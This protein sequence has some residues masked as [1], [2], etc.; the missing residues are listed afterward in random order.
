MNW[1]YRVQIINNSEFQIIERM[2]VNIINN[3]MEFLISTISITK[4]DTH[5]SSVTGS[6]SLPWLPCSS[7]CL[8]L[9]LFVSTK[10]SSCISCTFW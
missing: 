7:G 10:L 2:G 9:P 4:R 1:C 5:M 8:R 6:S 3:L